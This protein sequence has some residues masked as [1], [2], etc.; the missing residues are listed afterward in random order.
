MVTAPVD[1]LYATTELNEWAIA[2]AAGEVPEEEG[3][4]PALA[5]I[6]SAAAA[7]QGERPGALALVE[8][9]EAQGVPWLI[10]DEQL[11]LGYHDEA[12]SWPLGPGAEA[13]PAP[14]SVDWAGFPISRG[15]GARVGRRGAGALTVIT[16][17]NGKTTTTRMLVR[18]ARRAGLRVAN[19]STD[20]LFVDEALVEA[21]DWTGPGGA[22]SLLRRPGLDL[23]VLE[24]ARGG[25]LRRGLGVRR[26]AVSVITNVARD[27]L[28][29]YGIV[30][31]E[32]MAAA[33]GI[34][35]RA[36]DPQGRI[37]LSA[38]SPALVEWAKPRIRDAGQESRGDRDEA[39]PAPVIWISLDPSSPLLSAHLEAG[40]EVWTVLDGW[41][42]RSIEGGT[43]KLVPVEDMPSSFGGRARHNI[44]NAMAAAAAAWAL[45]IDERAIVSALLEFGARPEDNPGRARLWAV[46]LGE[47]QGSASVLVDFAHNLA[48]VEA[49]AE[50]VAGLVEER[51]C[52]P[53]VL[54]FGMAGDRGD[55]ELRALGAALVRGYHPRAVVLR[56]QHEYLRG[57][58][59]GEVPARLGEG[60]ITAGFEPGGIS[61]A[62]GEIESLERAL[63]TCVPGDVV[64]LLVHTQREVVREWLHERGA[65][66]E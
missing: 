28:G 7:E 66:L 21:G 4:E 35:A 59:V 45:G 65:R 32:G 61:M 34:V 17:T 60:L 20:G 48:G 47:G 18:M 56:E 26:C 53:P 27:H 10:D 52:R 43:R 11:S 49:I 55:D 16:G 42:A 13:L 2:L 5:G 62:E 15:A 58:E 39:L 30:D 12:R 50:L 22:R 44:A 29:E 57:R 31:L 51:G 23:A 63:A 19:T 46:P 37:V 14:A 24:T 36:T 3:D 9:A 33:K 54:C 8:A 41:L 38:D 25:L 40:G 6:A 1:R 64:V